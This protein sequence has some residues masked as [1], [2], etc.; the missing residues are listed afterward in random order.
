MD[1]MT[2]DPVSAARAGDAVAFRR[3]VDQHSRAVF[4]LCWRITRDEAL[5]E[6]AAQEAFYRAW[7]GL[8]DF[9]GRATFS[10]WL[11]QIAVNAALE[12]LRRNARHQSHRAELPSSDQDS[13]ADFLDFAENELPGPMDHVAADLLQR[14]VGQE[15]DRMS[16]LERTAFVLRHVEG[17][18]LEDIG[19]AL[20]LNTGQSKQA[21][22]RAVR[23]LRGA[24]VAWREA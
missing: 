24:L 8:A 20:D 15:L 7:R 19:A 6:N 11:H 14:R 16:V 18:S 1:A 10:T 13:E 2:A 22:F 12:Q 3:L 21:I 5:A 9:D 4:Q 23:K 17:A